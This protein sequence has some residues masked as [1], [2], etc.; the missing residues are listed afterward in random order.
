MPQVGPKKEKKKKKKERKKER[1]E[2]TLFLLLP[3]FLSLEGRHQWWR[4]GPNGFLV[5]QEE[6]H[7]KVG[8]SGRW[9]ES[10]SLGI[11]EDICQPWT[12]SSTV[13]FHRKQIPSLLFKPLLFG[14]FLPC[15]AE[16]FLT[17]TDYISYL[18]RDL[19]ALPIWAHLVPVQES[20]DDSFKSTLFRILS[21]PISYK[22]NY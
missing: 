9:E 13:L 6:A 18:M 3:S 2:G 4:W 21:S 15:G 16:P 8:R 20:H 1:K 12:A 7:P 17:S 22:S 19:A 10:G 14:I 11:H 5:H